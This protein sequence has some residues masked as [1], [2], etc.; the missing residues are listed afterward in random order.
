MKQKNRFLLILLI[1]SYLNSYSQVDSSLVAHFCFSG[2]VKDSS[3]YANHGRA[4]GILLHADRYDKLGQAVLFDGFGGISLSK[5]LPIGNTSHTVLLWVKIEAQFRGN[6]GTILSNAPHKPTA[7]WEIGMEGKMRLW[8][9]SGQVDLQS[10]V[11]LRDG[12]WHQLAFVRDTLNNRFYFYIDDKRKSALPGFKNRAGDH[13]KWTEPHKIGG[14]YREVPHSFNGLM[15][16]FRIYKRALTLTEIQN[17]FR[18]GKRTIRQEIE[19]YAVRQMKIWEQRNFREAAQ[20]YQIRMHPSLRDMK[21]VALYQ[22]AIFMVA[23]NNLL[24]KKSARHYND[25]KLDM[26]I[27]FENFQPIHIKITPNEADLMIRKFKYLEFSDYNF[28]LNKYGELLISRITIKNPISE[29]VFH[30]SSKSDFKNHEKE[31]FNIYQI[32]SLNKRVA[33][34]QINFNTGTDFLKPKAEK[35]LRALAKEFSL[36]NGLKISVLSIS[37]DAETEEENRQLAAKRS[38]KVL[39]YLLL[40]GAKKNTFVVEKNV[41]DFIFKQFETEINNGQL[42]IFRLQNF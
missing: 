36:V 35:Y 1:F 41:P 19:E 12:K 8:W 18:K 33:F 13:I 32:D 29:K 6:V 37:T 28:A 23:A 5:P 40:K 17:L 7:L 15:D 31:E 25:R 14:D 20:N 42:I 27:T 30:Y 22:E 2:N 38:Q 3:L 24:W 34:K 21:Q 4:E 16:D 11:D 10:S 9:N 26:K 39:D